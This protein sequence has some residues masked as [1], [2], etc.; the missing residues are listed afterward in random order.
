M[1]KKWTTVLLLL[2][3]LFL[4]GCSTS[5]EQETISPDELMPEQSESVNQDSGQYVGSVNSDK[6]HLPDCRWAGKIKPENEV[7]FDTK[8]EAEE[9]GY[10][11][12]KTCKP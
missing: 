2:A 4:V 8:E 5:T 7:W 10:I 12:C 1:L 3:C 6:Y 9:Q 11:P